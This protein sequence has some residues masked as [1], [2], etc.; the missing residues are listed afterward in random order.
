MDIAADD[1]VDAR[2]NRPS[3]EL[4]ARPPEPSDA[5]EQVSRALRGHALVRAAHALKTPLAVIKGSATTLLSG[6]GRWDLAAQ[7]EMLQLIDAQVDR[8]HDLVTGLLEV[9]RLESGLLPLQLEPICMRPF[10]EELALNWTSAAPAHPLRIALPDDLPTLPLDPERM[11]HALDRLIAWAV[12]CSAPDTAVSI[13]ARVGAGELLLLLAWQSSAPPSEDQAYRLEPFA[14]SASIDESASA[15][16]GLAPARAII[17]A[18]GGRIAA[19]APAQAPHQ[20]FEIALP[21]AP[22]P[23]PRP[24]TPAVPRPAPARRLRSRERPVVLVAHDDPHFAR[25]LRANLEDQGYRALVA[26]NAAQFI[27]LLDLEDPDLVLLDGGHPNRAHTSTLQ[28]L[29]E[30]GEVPAIVLG[31]SDEAECVRAL[32]LG[33]ADYLARPFGLP[34]LLARVR[35]ALRSS[36]RGVASEEP[37]PLFQ[38]GDLTIDFA[39]REVSVGGRAVR[40]SRTEYNLLRALAEHAGRVLTHEMLLERVWGP[41]YGREV[42]FLWVYVRRLRRKIEPDPRHPRYILTV[43]GVGYRLAQL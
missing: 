12:Q 25:Y 36:A 9:W 32:D 4:T 1:G 31:D 2:A 14:L 22:A 33:A 5:A 40:L 37:E 34:E 7:Q 41:G 16:L 13:E 42:E 20:M 43:P 3:S 24:A 28:L 19:G 27:R 21:L 35:V 17:C 23:T 39:Q 15:R 11:R 6:V 30:C 18:H 10:L 38:S 29:R 8:L 26:P